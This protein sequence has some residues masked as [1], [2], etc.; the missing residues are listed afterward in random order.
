M[1]WEVTTAKREEL[2]VVNAKEVWDYISGEELAYKYPFIFGA[3]FADHVKSSPGSPTCGEDF[4]VKDGG[5]E[6]GLNVLKLIP[7]EA[8][9]QIT[10]AIIW[11]TD[12][13][14]IRRAMIKDFSA[15]KM[16]L[17]SPA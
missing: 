10:L 6:N 13:G 3:G 2:I 4:K 5:K 11:V 14:I 9:Q 7:K 1:R 8:T 15:M 12:D 16:T 17:R